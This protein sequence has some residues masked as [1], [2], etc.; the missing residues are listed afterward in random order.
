MIVIIISRCHSI[1][2]LVLVM[3]PVALQGCT[4]HVG[5]L[6]WQV[7]GLWLRGDAVEGGGTERHREDARPGGVE[8][9]L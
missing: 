4:R 8:E 5:P 1:P 7:K 3:L 2:F 9:A 6:H